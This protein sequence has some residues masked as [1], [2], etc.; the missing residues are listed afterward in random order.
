[1]GFYSEDGE[2]KFSCYKNYY[3]FFMCGVPV[4][5]FTVVNCAVPIH[6]VRS[7]LGRKGENKQALNM[8]GCAKNKNLVKQNSLLRRR[9]H[10]SK[11]R[12]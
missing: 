8:L 4:R 6:S 11:M 12:I 2:G 10:G 1:M 9:E 3:F 5:A 7:R